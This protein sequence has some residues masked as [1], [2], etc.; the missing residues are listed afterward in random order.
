MNLRLRHPAVRSSVLVLLVA[1]LAPGAGASVQYKVDHAALTPLTA[2]TGSRVRIANIPIDGELE[3]LELEPFDVFAKD[4][5]INV[6]GANDETLETLAPPSIRLYR[7]AIAGDSDSMAFLSVSSSRVE[8]VVFKGDRRFGIGSRVRPHRQRTTEGAGLDVFVQES[9]VVD[10]FPVDGEGFTCEVEKGPISRRPTL[11]SVVSEMKVAADGALSSGSAR[12]VINMAIETDY[13]LYVNSGSSGT[14]V[15]T[16][17]T[18][19]IG[20]MST[21]YNRELTAEIQIS[22]LGIHTSPSDPFAIVPGQS[23]PWNSVPSVSYSSLHALLEF[24]DRWKNTPPS[25]AARSTTALIS[26][27]PQTSGVAWLDV[28]CQGDFT[29]GSNSS[30]PYRLHTG[31]RYTYNGGINP[32]D[33]LSVP[34][35]DVAPPY[36]VPSSNY[37]PLLQL[38]HETGHN[39]FSSHTHCRALSPADSVLY[40]RAYVDNCYNGEGGCYGGSPSIPTEKG[41]IMSYCHL[42]GGTNSRFIFGK[43][44][45]A[46]YVITND[47]KAAI[48]AVTP[49]LSTITVPASVGNGASANASVTNVAGVTYLWTVTN[50]VINSGQ[51]TSAINFTAN[52]NPATVRVK[53]TNSAGCSITDVQTVSVSTVPNPPAS[54]VATATTTSNVNVSWTASAGAT[55][56]NVYRS[57]GGNAYTLVGSTPSLTFNDGGRTANTAYLYKV[58]AVNGGESIDSNIDLATTVIF[59]DDPLTGGSTGLKAIHVTQLRT[60]V[61][62]VRTLAALGAGTFIDP[63]VTSGVTVIKPAHVTDLRTALN[64]ARSVLALSALTYADSI[65]TSVTKVKASHFTELRNGVR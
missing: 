46:S 53:A 22:Y 51:G 8:G 13:E 6:V 37:W 14:N 47:M 10:D 36:T 3:S 28:L 50:G 29:F 9:D 64:A 30:E 49:N 4:A 5:V 48:Q 35:P 43:T 63:T 21:I 65:T 59:T 27:K 33:N 60:A 56:Y 24:G 1:A 31:G 2:P 39:V 23:G 32:P 54:V 15:N 57:I 18:N 26:G 45:E 42:S 55:T 34:N 7:G 58:R 40:G 25:A 19:L 62:A 44:G 38:A 52:A 12:W 41:T 16:F 17:I 61:N 11:S 20:A